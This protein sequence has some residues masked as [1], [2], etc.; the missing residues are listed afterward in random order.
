MNDGV[1]ATFTKGSF[2]VYHRGTAYLNY[3]KTIGSSIPFADDVV[4]E[5]LSPGQIQ[6]EGPFKHKYTLYPAK[7]IPIRMEDGVEVPYLEG[8]FEL[9]YKEEKYL[10]MDRNPIFQ[11]KSSKDLHGYLKHEGDVIHVPFIVGIRGRAAHIFVKKSKTS[12]K[13]RA[14][15]DSLSA[16][17]YELSKKK[18]RVLETNAPAVL[19]HA[20]TALRSLKALMALDETVR[21]DEGV[22]CCMF[23][24]V[25]SSLQSTVSDLSRVICTAKGEKYVHGLDVDEL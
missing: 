3:D 17:D 7:T 19:E 5:F 6:V 1:D 13:K 21:R 2:L 20:K 4:G 25:R 24:D 16:A 9:E 22:K 12:S 14:K 8:S 18:T 15:A 23:D 11:N 10:L